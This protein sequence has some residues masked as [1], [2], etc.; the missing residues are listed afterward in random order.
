M[1]RIDDSLPSTMC[2]QRRYQLRQKA[3][4]LCQQCGCA[5]NTSK[6]LCDECR[7]RELEFAKQRYHNKKNA[8][9]KEGWP[10]VQRKV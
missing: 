10:F 2:R 5:T 4:G 8:P 1:L 6:R 7:L 3:A 9:L